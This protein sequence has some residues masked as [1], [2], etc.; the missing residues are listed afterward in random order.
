MVRGRRGCRLVGQR[1]EAVR[2]GGALAGD[3]PA[4]PT[5]SPD[6]H[7]R[8][9]RPPLPG[10][11]RLLRTRRGGGGPIEQGFARAGAL[12][13]TNTRTHRMEPDVPLLIPEVNADHLALVDWQRAPAAGRARSSPT[14]TARPPRW[15]WRSPPCSGHSESRRL[16]SSTMQAVS[17][18]GYPGV[19]SLDILGNVIPFIGGEEEK[20]ERESARS[21]APSPTAPWS[22]ADRGQRPR[23]S[24]GG[25]GWAHGGVSV[26]FGRRVAP[27]RSDRGA[28]RFRG[29]QR[30]QLAA[31]PDTAVSWIS[32]PDRPQSRLDLERGAGWR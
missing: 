20:I 18:A 19:P 9:V 30:G 6:G 22:R 27:G 29:S 11:H 14:R 25:D 21:S 15:R 24:G 32:R 23:Q 26:G 13:V 31:S 10:P 4:A 3:A 12:V 7:A 28:P 5:A 17:G 16:S 1:R 8:V 2:G